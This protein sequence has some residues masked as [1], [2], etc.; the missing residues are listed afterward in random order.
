MLRH[1]LRAVLTAAMIFGLGCAESEPER[2][3]PKPVGKAAAPAAAE[4]K[5]VPIADH[6]TLE[7]FP[8]RRRVLVEAEVCLREGP[9]EQLLTRKGRK[10]HEA[11]LAADVDARKIHEALLLARAKEGTPVRWLPTFRAPTGST[12]KVTLVYDDKGT[13]KSVSGRSWVKNRKSGK[14]LESDWVFAGSML[15]EN[16]FDK[17]APK[18]YL[19]NDG[20]VICLSNFEGAMLDLPMKSSKDDADRSYECWTERIPPTGTRVTVILEPVEEKKSDK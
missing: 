1:G 9:L 6:L 8:D 16:P 11:V 10:E 13:K 20:D 14:E 5:R 4:G 7:I 19:A 18:H 15:I 2:A 17:T 12:I 3:T